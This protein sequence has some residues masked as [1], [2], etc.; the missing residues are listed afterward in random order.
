MLVS[1]IK[2]HLLTCCDVESAP[3][4]YFSYVLFEFFVFIIIIFF[5][6]LEI[7]ILL[8]FANGFTM[9]GLEKMT[10]VLQDVSSS[11]PCVM[12]HI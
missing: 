5:L 11:W 8:R 7:T 12:T 2:K 3:F 1:V 10:F 9:T 4:C 6:M